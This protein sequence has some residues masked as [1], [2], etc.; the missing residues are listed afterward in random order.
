MKT[1]VLI[2]G[3][4]HGGWCWKDVAMQIRH[5]G[6]E[7]FTPTLTGLGERNHL[8]NYRVDLLTH[9][10]DVSNLINFEDLD[11]VV[12]VGHSYGGMVITGVASM[13]SEKIAR[14]VYLD[15][16]IPAAG[17]REFDLLDSDEAIGKHGDFVEDGI[18]LRPPASLEYL[19][20]ANLSERNRIA[21]KL[22]PL[23]LEVY[24]TPCPTPENEAVFDSIPRVY[25]HCTKGSSAKRFA[26][27]AEMARSHSWKVY[28]LLTGHDAMLTVPT[29]VTSLIVDSDS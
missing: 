18:W 24:N 21:K 10:Q 13:L 1:F 12:L 6:N 2:H 17:Q 5:L 19:G 29:D 20:I 25:I 28:E 9:I 3:S 16:F 22:T 26:P 27:F 7:V 8:R 15:A 14:L 11:E 4:W 23:P